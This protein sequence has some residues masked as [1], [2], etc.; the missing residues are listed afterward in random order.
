MRKMLFFVFSLF[1]L[2]SCD[3]TDEITTKITCLNSS[4]Y[5]AFVYFDYKEMFCIA[6]NDKNIKYYYPDGFNVEVKVVLCGVKKLDNGYRLYREDVIDEFS[7][8][9][10]FDSDLDYKLTIKNNELNCQSILVE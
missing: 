9:I 4:D 3:N 10:K 6:P 1:M 8:N 7:A 2:I 5:G